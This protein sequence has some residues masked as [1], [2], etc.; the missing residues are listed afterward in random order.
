MVK[1][2]TMITF[3]CH[4]DKLTYEETSYGSLSSRIV[5]QRVIGNLMKHGC[6]RYVFYTLEILLSNVLGFSE[7][8]R[9]HLMKDLL[10]ANDL[11][12][13]AFTHMI[14]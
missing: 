11:I 14:F 5:R 6:A 9:K 4:N 7:K 8:E 3:H 2:E 1:K 12:T 10:F 13:L